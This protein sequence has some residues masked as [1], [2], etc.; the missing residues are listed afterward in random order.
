MPARTRNLP[1]DNCHLITLNVVDWVDLF[2]NP[3]YRQI[4]ADALNH[5][6]ERPGLVIYAWC[7]MTNQL[8]LVIKTSDEYGIALFERD[9]KKFTTPEIVKA[10][11]HTDLRQDWMMERFENFSKSLRCSKRRWQTA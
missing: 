5:F 6:T 11:D 4:I 3:A 2:T 10:I 7:L 8:H 1:P 9:F